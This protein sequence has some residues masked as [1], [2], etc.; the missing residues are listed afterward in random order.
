MVLHLWIEKIMLIKVAD[1]RGREGMKKIFSKILVIFMLIVMLFE[2]V[3]PPEMY[4]KVTYAEDDKP[5]YETAG[6]AVINGLLTGVN[7]LVHQ[8]PG[9]D[10]IME[11]IRK[12]AEGTIAQDALELL[13]MDEFI[14]KKTAWYRPLA[15]SQSDLTG[16]TDF[17][18]NIYRNILF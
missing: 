16:V 12:L 6:K 3:M 13:T 18:N 9:A 2:V 14:P 7:W 15:T 5:W 1:E 17:I 11:E 10:A 4:S 8:V